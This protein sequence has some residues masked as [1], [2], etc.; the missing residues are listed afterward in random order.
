LQDG[1]AAKAVVEHIEKAGGEAFVF[2]A[3]VAVQAEVEA[4]V[5]AAVDKW[6]HLD[7][8]VNNSAVSGSPAPIERETEAQVDLITAVN[9]KGTLWG[10]QAAAKVLQSGGSIINV[11]SRAATLS[12]PNFGVYAGLKSAVDTL[13]RTAAAELGPRGIRVNAVSPGMVETDMSNGAM[14]EELRAMVKQQTPLEHRT[15]RPEEIADVVAF[16]AS[17]EASWVT[18]QV[19]ALAGGF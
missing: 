6:G 8:F 17:D 14:T 19:I 3:D 5:A 1:E 16:L 15:G 4:L 11:S 12:F 13:T 18:A 9:F 7:V 10:I 2:R